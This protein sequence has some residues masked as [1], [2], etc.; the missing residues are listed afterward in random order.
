MKRIQRSVLIIDDSPEDRLAFRRFLQRDPDIAYTCSEA[1]TAAEG[2]ARCRERLP[3]VVLL[4][5]ELPDDDGLTTLAALIAAY[6]SHAF[7]ILLL[8]GAGDEQ[9]A[10]AA[11][12]IG[13]HDYLVKSPDI[14]YPLRRAVAGAIE[15]A[16]L[17]RELAQQRLALEA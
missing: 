11:L 12:K 17:Q 4:D 1:I 15:K 10:V 3:D 13:A 7:A 8:T 6:G 14:E 9:V 5:Y 16:G 2:L